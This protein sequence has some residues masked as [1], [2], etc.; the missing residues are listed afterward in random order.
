[1]TGSAPIRGEVMAMLSK[2]T[3]SVAPPTIQR[4]IAPDTTGGVDTQVRVRCHR[5]RK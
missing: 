3:P 2:H 1:M 4:V 5:R